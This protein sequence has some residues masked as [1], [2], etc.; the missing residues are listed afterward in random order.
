M[1][2]A[3]DWWSMWQSQCSPTSR[4]TLKLLVTSAI[5]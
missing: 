1:T 4:E 3:H 2:K 5:V